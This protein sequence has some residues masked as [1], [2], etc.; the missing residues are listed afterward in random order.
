MVLA[1]C[2]SM[3]T[4]WLVCACG[5]GVVCVCSG[6]GW[7]RGP[8]GDRLSRAL[9]H[10]IIGA[11]GFHVRVRDGIGWYPAAMATRLSEPT[12]VRRVVVRCTWGSGSGCP[13]SSSMSGDVCLRCWT[14]PVLERGPTLDGVDRCCAGWSHMQCA[15]IACKGLS[16]SG[17]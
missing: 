8:G 5:C 10:S 7:F 12:L 14:W 17:D 13:A 4:I 3:G 11:G 9:R 2:V 15:S 6:S 1:W 16:R